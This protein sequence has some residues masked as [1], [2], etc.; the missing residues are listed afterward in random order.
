MPHVMAVLNVE[1]ADRW[2]GQFNSEESRAERK[3]HGEVGYQIFSVADQPNVLVLLC[4]F[5]DMARLQAFMASDT[6]RDFQ[7]Q[8]GVLGKPEV[9]LFS[10]VEQGTP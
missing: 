9:Y 3:S 5:Q 4:E 7:Q 8:S 1:D 10:G 2:M 6:L